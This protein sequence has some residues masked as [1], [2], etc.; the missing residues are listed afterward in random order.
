M[1]VTELSSASGEASPKPAEMCR[2]KSVAPSS[3]SSK[4]APLPPLRPLL[5]RDEISPSDFAMD[6]APYGEADMAVKALQ[7]VLS[8]KFGGVFT[9]VH[10]RCC[11]HSH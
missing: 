5:I 10:S 1:R 9:Q 3:L 11:K 4:S 6:D 2:V 7:S 8:S